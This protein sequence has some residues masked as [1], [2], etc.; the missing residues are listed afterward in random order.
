MRQRLAA[1]RQ[2]YVTPLQNRM[3]RT[4][5]QLPPRQT[6]AVCAV[7]ST[8]YSFFAGVRTDAL[9]TCERA[10]GAYIY[11][12]NVAGQYPDGPW[13]A[14]EQYVLLSVDGY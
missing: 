6:G 4:K 8:S 3:L 10:S 12:T 13:P 2:K 5:Q 9:S 7:R 11:P 1:A 14:G